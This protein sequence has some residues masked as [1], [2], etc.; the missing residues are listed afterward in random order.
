MQ[1]AAPCVPRHPRLSVQRADQGAALSPAR[2]HCRSD[3][4]RVGSFPCTPCV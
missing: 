1:A 3:Q 4:V 2:G